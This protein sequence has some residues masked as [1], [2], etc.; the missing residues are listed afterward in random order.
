MVGDISV[1]PKTIEK[2]SINKC[3]KLTGKFTT[4]R[5]S[6]DLDVLWRNEPHT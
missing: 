4:P 1:L 5:Q 3:E 2:L 6:I